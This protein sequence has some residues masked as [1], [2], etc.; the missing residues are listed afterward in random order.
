MIRTPPK[1][2]RT[3]TL[4]PYTTLFRSILSPSRTLR[5]E[6]TYRDFRYRSVAYDRQDGPQADISLTAWYSVAP[7]W[8]LFGGPDF[9][10]K[11]TDD[12]VDSYDQGG[13]RLGLNTSFGTNA[14]SEERRVGKEG[15]Q[16]V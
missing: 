3:D 13:V 1:S 2:T 16:Y 15:V 12:P 14:R 5:L 9:S 7:G 10:V 11:D 4:F 8:T 6:G